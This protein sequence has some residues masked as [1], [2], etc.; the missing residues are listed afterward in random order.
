M[1]KP[2][3]SLRYLRGFTLMGL[4]FW[5]IVVAM[6]AILI[7]KVAPTVNEYMTIKKA[8]AKIAKEATSVQDVRNAFEKQKQVEYGM[9]SLSG[10]D[11]IVTKEND[12]L[13]VSFAYNKEIELVGP[14]SL[15][16]K[17]KGQSK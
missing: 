11:L 14:V 5:S 10:Q 12:K 6:G 13:V 9:E 2:V 7:M 1:F 4:L 16:I 3:H 17:Y 15:L 8:V